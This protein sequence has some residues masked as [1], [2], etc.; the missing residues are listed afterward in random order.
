[1]GVLLGQTREG[2][3]SEVDTGERIRQTHEGIFM[4]ELKQGER[5]FC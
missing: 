2:M 5:M 3:F 1:M 4:K